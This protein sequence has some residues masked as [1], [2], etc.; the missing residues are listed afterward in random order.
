[1]ISENIFAGKI[2]GEMIVNLTS[3]FM[4]KCTLKKNFI[5]PAENWQKSPKI[6]SD[7]NI[8][9]RKLEPVPI[10]DLGVDFNLRKGWDVHVFLHEAGEEFWLELGQ[11]PAFH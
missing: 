3:N 10:F 2:L 5:F 8:G 6:G 1:M 11:W 4:T 7:H 9:S